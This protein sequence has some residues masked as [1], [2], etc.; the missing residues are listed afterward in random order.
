M[1]SKSEKYCRF[2]IRKTEFRYSFPVKVRF[3][4]EGRGDYMFVSTPPGRIMSSFVQRNAGNFKHF[5]YYVIPQEMLFFGF[6]LF[7]P[8][9]SL[10]N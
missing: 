4:R 8:Y 3:P 6:L 5:Q 10:E 1:L 2:S 7:L 9:K